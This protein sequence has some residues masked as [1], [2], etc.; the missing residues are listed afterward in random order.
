MAEADL[1]IGVTGNDMVNI[2]GC[3]FAKAIGCRTIAR[4]NEP[5]LLDWPFEPDPQAVFGLDAYISPDELAM[6]RIWQ[7]L[8]RPALTRLEHFSVG[9]LRILEVRLD[10]SSPAVGR[11]LDSIELPPHC[12]VVLVS[13]DEG[14]IIPR[15]EE[16][17]LPRDRLLVLLSDV[18]E[19]E[20]LSESLGAPKEVTGEGNIKRL[21][22]AGSTQVAL[23]LAEQVARRYDGVQVY[24][25]E[26]DRARA[27]EVSER[28]SD[29]VTVLVGSPTDRH[30]LREEGI[31]HED[32]FVAATERE[33][34][35]MLSCLLAKR[36]GAR[37][38]VALVYQTE[39]EHVVQNTG[40]DT[41]INPKRV[42]VTAILNRATTTEEIEALEELQGGEASIRE[43]LVKA[44]N[45][46]VGK[47]IAKL[48]LPEG[49]MVALINR[50]GEPFFP[51]EDE[52]LRGSDHLLVFTLK[53]QLPALEK[54]FR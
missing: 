38:T 45:G 50:G 43:F 35:N 53:G 11:T 16:V 41:L 54:L 9:K 5:Q 44:D 1:F 33:D 17:L 15:S 14:I 4:V 32:L 40:V 6:H 23:R 24:L 26:P 34:L 12:R 2:L 47:S 19:L 37:R 39:L 18:H 25:V 22:I 29:D 21:M 48:E 28:L 30:F 36:E 13:R 27:E 8:S 51:D 52:V 46:L 49:S 7:I 42:A 3:T 31:R 20:E 10:D